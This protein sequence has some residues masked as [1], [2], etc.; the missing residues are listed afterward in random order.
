M[1]HDDFKF[2][3]IR[4]LP[5]TLPADEHILWQGAPNPLRLA[6]DAWALNW[7]LGYFSLLA[8]AR[9]IVASGEVPLTAAMA[10]GVPFLVAGAL[11][12]MIVIGMA[13]V[14]ARSTV[15]TLTNKRACMRIGAALTM[16]LNLPYVCIANANAAVRPSGLGTITVELMGDTRLSYLMTWPHVRPW[17][18]RRTQPSFR[19]I[20]DAARVAAIFADAAETRVST[21]KIAPVSIPNAVPAE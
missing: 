11:V 4:G 12:A 5:E 6:K 15:Y 17:T 8:M 3:P 14:Q 10:Q 9:V 18:M 16:T 20:P 13:T 2:E 1:H 19:A 7:I 21:P